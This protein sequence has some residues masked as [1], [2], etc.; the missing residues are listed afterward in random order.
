MAGNPVTING[1]FSSSAPGAGDF[2]EFQSKLSQKAKGTPIAAMSEMPKGVPLKLDTST[3][4]THF[5]LPSMTPEQS[6]KVREML[7]KRPPVVTHTTVTSI[8]TK[9]LPP[10]TFAVPAGYTKEQMPMRG[11]P[12]AAPSGPPS[13]GGA[14]SGGSSSSKVPE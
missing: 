6:A 4:M 2:D 3:K 8:E 7:A 9:S 10:E 12:G 5:S 13:S 1:C 14:G 11:M